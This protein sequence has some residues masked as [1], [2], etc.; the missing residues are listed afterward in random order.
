MQLFSRKNQ[1]QNYII[2]TTFALNE[3]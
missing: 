2:L 1:A 3:G